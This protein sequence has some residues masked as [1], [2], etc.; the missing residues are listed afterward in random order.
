VRGAK[1]VEEQARSLH[2]FNRCDLPTKL[3]ELRAH[4]I[5]DEEE[6]A[7]EARKLAA[8]VVEASNTLVDLGMLPIQEVPQNPKKA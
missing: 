1:L 3:G 5:G 7:T 4:A 6:R 8:L 2:S